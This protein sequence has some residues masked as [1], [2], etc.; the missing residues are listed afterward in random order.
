MRYNNNSVALLIFVIGI[1]TAVFVSNSVDKTWLEQSY[2]YDVYQIDS[3]ESAYKFKGKEVIISG[4]I[5]YHE[6]ILNQQHLN[7]ITA[8]PT[9]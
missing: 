7:G 8:A 3:G 2:L 9:L 4:A 1:F 6:S 5:P